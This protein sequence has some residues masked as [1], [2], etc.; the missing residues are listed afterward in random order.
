MI[1]VS[2]ATAKDLGAFRF[3]KMVHAQNVPWA[4]TLKGGVCASN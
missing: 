1:L 4:I 3:T 2:F